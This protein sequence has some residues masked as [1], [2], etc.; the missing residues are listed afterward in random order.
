MK[1]VGALHHSNIVGAHDADEIDGVH[2]LVMEY[3]EGIDVAEL[4]RQ[5]GPLQ[6]A[7]ACELVRQAAIGLDYAHRRGLVHRDVEPSN[8]MLDGQGQVKVLD[9]GLALVA[10]ADDVD[11]LTSAG[12]RWARLITCARTDR[13]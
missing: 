13:R 11:E 8:L 2:F 6:V 7:D 5:V 3:V 1:A 12:T 4:A 9:L 10:S